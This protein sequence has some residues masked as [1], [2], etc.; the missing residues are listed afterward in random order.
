MIRLA[1][2]AAPVTAFVLAV[3]LA[4]CVQVDSPRPSE[5]AA[6]PSPTARA[7][8]AAGGGVE[9]LAPVRAVARPP[10]PDFS[11]RFQ[12]VLLPDHCAD[13]DIAAPV[14][15][16]I[17]LTLLDRTYA[18]PAAYVPPDLVPASR[19]GFV[20]SS[21][22]RLVRAIV[23]D[24]LAAM[25]T[26]WEAAG[27]TVTIDSAYRSSATQA[28]TFNSW[29]ARLGYAEGLLRSARPGHSEHQLGTAFDFTSPGWD[30][31]LGDWAAETPEGAW[32]AAHGWEY[33]FVMSYPAF[34]TP[35]TCFGYEP[36]H[37]RW[38]GRELAADQQSSGMVLRRFLERF[39]TG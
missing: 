28:A 21:A 14:S 15:G 16:D 32:L 11:A 39:A 18:L 29:V 19:A 2:L 22:D 1:G 12:A 38:I 13:R 24:D 36:W 23:V 30:G 9:R 34:A 5:A 27:L 26:A 3:S 33:G 31:R 6:S 35:D 37:Y 20:G 4:A 7:V 25:R 10:E 8:T 17:T